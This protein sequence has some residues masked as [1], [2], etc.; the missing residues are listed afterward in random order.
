MKTF[1]KYVWRGALLAC[2]IVLAG[3]TTTVVEPASSTGWHCVAHDSP[4]PGGAMRSWYFNSANKQ[5]AINQARKEC[6]RNSKYGG[7]YVARGACSRL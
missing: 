4:T 6:K 5:T 3:C 2:I 7:C 1:S